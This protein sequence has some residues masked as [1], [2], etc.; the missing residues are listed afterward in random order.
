[1]LRGPLGCKMYLVDELCYI[2]IMRDEILEQFAA[3]NFLMERISGVLNYTVPATNADYE[4]LLQKASKMIHY[5]RTT[6]VTRENLCGENSELC[7]SCIT[8]NADCLYTKAYVNKT[9]VDENREVSYCSDPISWKVLNYQPTLLYKK[10]NIIDIINNVP[11]TTCPFYKQSDFK[12]S[13]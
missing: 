12:K 6:E 4:Y 10:N 13:T 9:F 11:Y 8:S 5:H 1:M 3:H 7:Q 2:S